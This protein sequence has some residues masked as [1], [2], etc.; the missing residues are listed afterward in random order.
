MNLHAGK[1][2]P[3]ASKK[4][5][6]P[7]TVHVRRVAVFGVVLVRMFPYTADGGG[8]GTVDLT[9]FVDVTWQ[10]VLRRLRAHSP[11]E[12]YIVTGSAGCWHG[13]IWAGSIGGGVLGFCLYNRNDCR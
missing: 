5:R 8:V 4:S 2:S 13:R 6:P 12:T 11:K 7:T 3:P 10:I 9:V 1:L